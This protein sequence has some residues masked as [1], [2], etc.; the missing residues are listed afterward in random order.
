MTI[1]TPLLVYDGDC[2]FCRRQVERWRDITG[3]RVDYA[4]ATEVQHRYPQVTSAM[5]MS[6]VVLLTPDGETLTGA[7]AVLTALGGWKLWSYRRL[8]GVRPVAEMVY[9]F[10]ARH[11]HAASAVTRVLSGPDPGPST[12]AI[13]AW[14]FQRLVGVTFLIAFVSLWTQIHG[15]IGD[16]GI[17]PAH[18]YLLWARD[19]LGTACYRRLPTVCW[20][21]TDGAFLD[22]L[23]GFGVVTALLLTLG[24]APVPSLAVLWIVYLQT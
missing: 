1:D 18:E 16:D 2:G 23:C 15:L 22:V 10:V 17:L 20:L 3:D 5:T 4:P 21:S 9:T 8:P 6:S 24:I 13:A 19:N 7:A 14:T 11:R 12:C